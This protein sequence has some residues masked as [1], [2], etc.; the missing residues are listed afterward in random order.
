MVDS[1]KEVR[2]VVMKYKL[3]TDL[4]IKFLGKTLYRIEALVSFG[5]VKKGDLGGYVESKKNLSQ[6]SGDARVSGNAQ[7]FGN[8]RGV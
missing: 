7:V 4:S 2:G 3:R 5:N 6:V 1:I 8:A